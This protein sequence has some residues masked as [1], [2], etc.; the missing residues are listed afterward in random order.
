VERGGIE[1]RPGQ[2]MGAPVARLLENG[3]L[4]G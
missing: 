3:D 4:Q 1:N 2:L